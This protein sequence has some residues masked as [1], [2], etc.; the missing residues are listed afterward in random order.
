MDY[1]TF[2]GE[3]QNR[4]QLPSREDAVRVIRITLET[5]SERLEPGAADNLAAQLPDEIGRHL[6]KVDEVEGFGWDEFV[7]RI[8]EKG[9]YDPDDE[10]ADA[11][12]HARSVIDVVEEATTAGELEDV[13]AQL[14]EE[15]E[16]LF[17]LADQAEKPVEEEQRPEDQQS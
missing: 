6:S 13:R 10:A 5:F 2:V 15:F 16:E 1:D 17:V 3:V 14:P 12:H 7:D 8:V 11:V 4:A 9:G